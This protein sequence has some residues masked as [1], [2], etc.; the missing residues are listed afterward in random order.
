MCGYLELWSGSDPIGTAG[1]PASP[2]CRSSTSFANDT[3]V[4]PAVTAAQA[5]DLTVRFVARTVSG[6]PRVEVDQAVLSL[7][8]SRS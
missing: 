5:R 4:L 2:V 8:W 7:A 6:A 1:S 3:F